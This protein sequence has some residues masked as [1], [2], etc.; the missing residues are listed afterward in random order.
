MPEP[1]PSQVLRLIKR[2][3]GFSAAE[4]IWLGMATVAALS[5]MI[6]S[7]LLRCP[8]PLV[9]AFA[10]AAIAVAKLEVEDL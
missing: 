3:R 9:F 8:M 4:K 6:L 5:G 10:F 7:C 1:I 2:E